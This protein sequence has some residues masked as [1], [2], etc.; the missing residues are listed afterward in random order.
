MKI[1]LVGANWFDGAGRKEGRKDGRVDKHTDRQ[2]DRHTDDQTYR[3][4]DIQTIRHT[5]GQTYRQT[6]RRIDMTK[7]I[8]SFR[9]SS[10]A[11]KDKK[12]P[13]NSM[14]QRHILLFCVFFV[15]KCVLYYCHRLSTQ[16]QLTNISISLSI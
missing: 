11:P 5:D 9:N 2:T 15:C 10:N 12:F 8:V 3:R 16:L 13:K 6:Y 14:R 7:L 1:C 4:S